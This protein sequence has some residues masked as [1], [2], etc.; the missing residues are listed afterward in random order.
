MRN[1]KIKERKTTV[2]LGHAL[3]TILT[4]E[5]DLAA[6]VFLFL[7]GMCCNPRSVNNEALLKSKVRKK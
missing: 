4:I 1:R 3:M 5:T 2:S 7:Y 6:L